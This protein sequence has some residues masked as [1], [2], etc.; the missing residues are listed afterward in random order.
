MLQSEDYVATVLTMGL[1]W[2]RSRNHTVL[3][4]HELFA[5]RLDGNCET[6]FRGVL[7]DL[8]AFAWEQRDVM[9]FPDLRVIHLSCKCDSHR[10]RNHLLKQTADLAL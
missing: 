10:R 5:A 7:D 3:L 1:K 2:R 6:D 4:L 8:L 9:S